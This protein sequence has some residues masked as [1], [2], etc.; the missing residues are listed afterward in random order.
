MRGVSWV[1]EDMLASQ[2]G[3][4]SIELIVLFTNMAGGRIIQVGGSL[5]DPCY[6]LVTASS[7]SAWVVLELRPSGCELCCCELGNKW[8]NLPGW[9]L[10][11]VWQPTSPSRASSPQATTLHLFPVERLIDTTACLEQAGSVPKLTSDYSQEAERSQS[12]WN[13]HLQHLPIFSFLGTVQKLWK[14]DVTR[15]FGHLVMDPSGGSR[16]IRN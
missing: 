12:A 11:S 14:S 8:K 5:W 9:W 15:T 2:E 16:L 4:Y 6:E 3:L 10:T 1:T 13:R 7:P